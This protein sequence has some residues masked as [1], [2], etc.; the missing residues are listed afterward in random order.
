MKVKIIR[1]VMVAGVRKDP[2]ET[3]EVSKND[4]DLL[5]GSGKAELFVE[6]P[7]KAAPKPVAKK[8]T[9]E[10]KVPSKPETS[11]KGA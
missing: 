2:G 11:P 5:I 1:N 3:I 8:E 6:T 9:P 7:K 10:P 4:C